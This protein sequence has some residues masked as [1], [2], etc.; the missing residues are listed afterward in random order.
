MHTRRPT[1][2][3]S[4]GAHHN[5]A[6]QH[7][8]THEHLSNVAITLTGQLRTFVAHPYAWRTMRVA[9]IVPLA[10]DTSMRKYLLRPCE[11]HVK[12]VWLWAK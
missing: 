7:Y 12:A 11:N 4:Q 6:S 10:A 2:G 5:T 9:V 3:E 8:I 1:R